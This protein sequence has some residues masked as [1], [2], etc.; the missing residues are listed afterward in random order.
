MTKPVILKPLWT[1]QN[2]WK[3]VND[4]KKLYQRF[5]LPDNTYLIGSFQRD[6]EGNSIYN[7]SYMPKLEKGPDIF[8]EVIKSL[9]LIVETKLKNMESKD[10]KMSHLV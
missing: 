6:T 1:N 5:N 2:T 8:L 10:L 7:K 4:K 9:W 3:V